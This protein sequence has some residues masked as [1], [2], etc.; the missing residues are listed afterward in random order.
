MLADL[1]NT[2]TMI[3]EAL[4]DFSGR[5]LLSSSEV[6]DV[7]LDLLGQIKMMMETETE[8]G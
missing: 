1:D 2:K 8:R 4:S 6:T 5:S 3:T 7:L